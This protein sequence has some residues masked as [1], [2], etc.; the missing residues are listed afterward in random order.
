MSSVINYKDNNNTWRG[1]PALRGPKGDKGDKGDPGSGGGTSDYTDLTNKPSINSVTLTG[2]KTASDLGLAKASDIP[3]VSGLASKSYVDNMALKTVN[4]ESIKGSGNIEA[5]VSDEVLG[6]KIDEYFTEHPIEGATTE[7]VDG[8]FD[9]QFG[10]F[11]YNY[12]DFANGDY[13]ASNR[14]FATY[15]NGHFSVRVVTHTYDTTIKFPTFLLPKGNYVVKR[16]GSENLEHGTYIY[17]KNIA[18]N[19]NV[20]Y[21]RWKRDDASAMK[22]YNFE[23]TED[24]QVQIWLSNK[25]TF[26][27]GEYQF[28]L[29]IANID[30]DVIG[31]VATSD[32]YKLNAIAEQVDRK[33]N[34]SNILSGKKWAV[35]GDSFSY[36][37]W[38]GISNQNS[39]I[40]LQE[41]KYAGYNRVYGYVIGNRNDMD[42]VMLA[43]NGQTM[44]TPSEGTF[45]NCFS[46]ELYTTIPSDVDYITLYFGINDFHHKDASSGGD[47]EDNT[48]IIPIGNVD[49][50]TVNTFCGAYNV[51][52]DYLVEN[53]P[54]AHIGIIVSNGITST[55]DYRD[56]T[57]AIAKK[58]GIPY[59]DLNGDNHTPAMIRS[60]NSEIASSVKEVI[61]A[62]FRCTESNTHPN[63]EAHEYESTFIE[64][65]LRSL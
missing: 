22:L 4:G 56:K 63:P 43:Q 52:L 61:N 44:A 7:Y 54:F 17:V 59:I 8:K 21:L 58:H 20:A 23:L 31:F 35:C 3:D 65:F 64:N 5:T 29:L 46:N 13:S 26:Y 30:D 14:S 27:S 1:I 48:G 38:G 25:N 34:A 41:R 60:C 15:S 33:A 55:T 51:V 10:S 16:F 9:E 24:T 12:L 62:K 53:Y 57:I 40:Y 42:I 11:K 37:S 28:D 45:T 2:N 6:T 39:R 18:N 36:G 32:N 49:D 19:S 50:N 47:G